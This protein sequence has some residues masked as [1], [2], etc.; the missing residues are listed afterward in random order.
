MASR[1]NRSRPCRAG[2]GRYTVRD[3]P[4][5]HSRGSTRYRNPLA[6]WLRRPRAAARCFDRERE[7][8]SSLRRHTP[9]RRIKRQ[10]SFAATVL[11]DRECD[12]S[13]RDRPRTGRAVVFEHVVDNGS[14]SRSRGAGNDTDP[15]IARNR[16]PGALC[17]SQDFY[18]TPRH[19]PCWHGVAGGI[20]H[21][22]GPAP[23]A[24]LHRERLASRRYRTCPGGASIRS[25]RVVYC[26]KSSASPSGG[27][28]YPGNI[29]RRR[30]WTRRGRLNLEITGRPRR[31]HVLRGGHECRVA[32]APLLL[33]DIEGLAPSRNAPRACR[34]GVRRHGIGNRSRA[35][36]TRPRNHRDPRI[37]CRSRP[38]ASTGNLNL[39]GQGCSPGTGDRGTRRTQGHVC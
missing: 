8:A 12:A 13:S 34:C 6:V 19:A 30:P 5:P 33:I 20:Q 27:Y 11:I 17:R 15:R 10:I 24:L 39:K 35:R 3:S 9:P 14:R 28:S 1:R 22:V 4:V 2:V 36:T 7:S 29:G 31:G 21:R 38:R 37:V 16:R 25:Y 18:R 23:I 32:R 26:A